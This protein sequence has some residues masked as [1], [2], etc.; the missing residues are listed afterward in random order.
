MS[1]Q[2]LIGFDEGEG[3][4]YLEQ[5]IGVSNMGDSS[6]NAV[7]S[8]TDWEQSVAKL[9]NSNYRT[10]NARNYIQKFIQFEYRN[11]TTVKSSQMIDTTSSSSPQSTTPTVPV[12]YKSYILK[13]SCLFYQSQQRKPL[14]DSYT[15][16]LRGRHDQL[17]W[18]ICIRNWDISKSF[19]SV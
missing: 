7:A 1:L 12:N 6:D 9:V 3:V 15:R 18:P 5:L 17:N 4:N 13:V 10:V 2:V 14:H 16:I 19:D 8:K 11:W